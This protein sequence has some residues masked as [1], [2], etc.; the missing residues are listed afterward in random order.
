MRVEFSQDALD[1]VGLEFK[2]AVEVLRMATKAIK[3]APVGQI[4]FGVDWEGETVELA[5]D[6]DFRMVDEVMSQLG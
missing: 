6:E 2:P 4:N 5:L 3:R 1:L